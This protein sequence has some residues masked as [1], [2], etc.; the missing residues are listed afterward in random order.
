MLLIGSET[1]KLF[2][3]FFPLFCINFQ[4]KFACQGAKTFNL[5]LEQRLLPKHTARKFTGPL[6]DISRRARGR[7]RAAAAASALSG[8]RSQ[9][10][11]AT[12]SHKSRSCSWT[13][14]CAG[15]PGCVCATND[16]VEPKTLHGEKLLPASAPPF[17]LARPLSGAENLSLRL[18]TACWRVTEYQGVTRR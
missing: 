14:Y 7:R 15:Q 8:E 1:L 3:F 16:R 12:T 13:L 5:E 11:T 9:Q 6:P 2:F 17:V 18:K 4:L 10:K